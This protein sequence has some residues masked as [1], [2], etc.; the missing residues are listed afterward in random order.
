MH[1][2]VPFVLSLLFTVLF[3][4]SPVYASDCSEASPGGNLRISTACG[5]QGT[6]NGVDSGTGTQ[7]TANLSID[8]GGTLTVFWGQTL[9]VGSLT[10]NGGSMVLINGSSFSIGSPIWMIDKDADGFPAT[11]NQY[12]GNTPPTNARRR[13]ELMTMKTADKNDTYHCPDGYNPNVTCNYCKIGGLTYERAEFD[14]YNQCP[15]YSLCNGL[16]SCSQYAKRVFISSNSYNGYLGGLSGADQICQNLAASASI[17][18]IWK[19][20]LSDSTASAGGRLTQWNHWYVLPDTITKIA[21]NW[22]ELTSGSLLSPINQTETGA[23]VSGRT[24]WTNTGSNGSQVSTDT[25][26]TCSDWFT[27]AGSRS[28]G[29]GTNTL[30]TSGQWTN[31]TSDLCN[32]FKYLYCFEQ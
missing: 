10:L 32:K 27:H 20:W 18:G 29:Y 1:S 30:Y 15:T 21:N 2:F 13:N 28:G 16:G 8:P 31:T 5:F 6:V 25:A 3:R 22:I 12:I 11:T 14:R 4:P 23:T 26:L 17:S 19:A 9:A 7:N 24:V